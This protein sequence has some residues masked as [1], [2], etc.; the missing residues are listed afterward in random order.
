MLCFSLV[1]EEIVH[2]NAEIGSDF[3]CIISGKT[4]LPATFK[5]S[6]NTGLNA[7]IFT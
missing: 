3:V 7:D 4:F 5:V 2:G 1:A 6:K